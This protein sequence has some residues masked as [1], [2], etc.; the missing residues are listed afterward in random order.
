MGGRIS[1]CGGRLRAFQDP[2]R[3]LTRRAEASRGAYRAAAHPGDARRARR[4]TRGTLAGPGERYVTDAHPPPL[5]R[6]GQLSGEST[7]AVP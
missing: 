7:T 3:L 4:A 1:P 6:R 2:D 5:A